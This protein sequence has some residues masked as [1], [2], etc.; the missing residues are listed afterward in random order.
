MSSSSK[1]KKTKL[2]VKIAISLSLGELIILQPITPAALQPNPMHMVSA[3]F[4]EV[5]AFLNSESR[6]NA[7]RGKMPISSRIVNRG[8]NIAIGGSITATTQATVLYIPWIKILEIKVGQFIKSEKIN[9][10]SSI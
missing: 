3:C 7:I 9:S 5:Q 4:P 8:K 1:Q 6:L 10:F 2:L